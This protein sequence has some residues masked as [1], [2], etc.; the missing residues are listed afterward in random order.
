MWIINLVAW[1]F[2]IMAFISPLLL[3]Y[4]VIMW[5]RLPGDERVY[6]RLI[7][8]LVVAFCAAAL[9]LLGSLIFTEVTLSETSLIGIAAFAG[10]FKVR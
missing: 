6:H 7:D 3:V 4:G 1:L 8:G 5:I 9:L 2:R 10:S